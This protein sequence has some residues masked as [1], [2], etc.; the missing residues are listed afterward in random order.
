MN[1]R[2]GKKSNK[3]KLLKRGEKDRGSGGMNGRRIGGK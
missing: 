1:K 3:N 2:G